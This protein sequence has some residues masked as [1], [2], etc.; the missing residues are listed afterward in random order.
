[1]NSSRTIWVIVFMV[2]FFAVLV[3]RLFNV[4]I[5]KSDELKYFARRQ[6][7]T[8]EKVSADRGLIY[9]RNGVLLV[10]SRNDVSFYLDLRMLQKKDKKKIA[11][12]FS[13]VFSE[14]RSHYYDLMKDS[15]KTICLE[16]KVSSEKAV[17]LKNFR[18]NGLFY[19]EDPTQ[20]YYYKSLASHLLGYVDGDYKGVDGI[21]KSYNDLLS[22]QDGNMLILRDAIG[23]MITV[24]E[25]ETKPAVPGSN[26]YLTIN[27]TYQNIIEEELRDGVQKYGGSSAVGI[28]MDPNNGQVLALANSSDYDPNE[29]W[30]Y[31]DSLR[32]DRA[33]T[34]TYEPGST[35]KTF[36]FA[37]LLDENK[38]NLNEQ[39]Y[40]ENG[41]Y[42]FKNVYITDSHNSQ[43][44]TVRGVLEQSSNIGMAKL[45]QRIDDDSFY[46]YLRGFGFGNMT[47]INLPGEVRGTLRKPTDWDEVSKAF[48]SFGYGV[49]VT[50]IR[51]I[52][53]Y[54]AVINGGIL[55]QPL[56][57]EKEVKRDGQLI[58]QSTPIKIRQ[59]ISEETSKRMRSA[60]W[61]CKGRHRNKCAD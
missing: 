53:A 17:T 49:T 54:S 32:R 45:A 61:C 6:Q 28:I 13:S 40:A 2:G 46:K 60:C 1:M 50:P 5:L 55:Y 8:T 27:K 19:R 33:V 26:I 11:E 4:Q 29:Y 38:C 42:K 39:V 7:M 25:K 12:K 47:S 18:V 35:F 34:D 23:D 14:S 48:I 37:S 21:A 41:K 9:D 56:I 51:L 10:Y 57:I 15:S 22:G 52:T 59:V 31:S 16:K 3:A 44:L 58:L 20:V 43:W 24:S 30:K 36:S